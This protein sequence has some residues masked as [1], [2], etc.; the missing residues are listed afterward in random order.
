MLK[1][2][3]SSLLNYYKSPTEFTVWKMNGKKTRFDAKEHMYRTT[4]IIIY[5]THNVFTT[6]NVPRNSIFATWIFTNTLNFPLNNHTCDGIKMKRKITL[7]TKTTLTVTHRSKCINF[8]WKSQ[9]I[10][11]LACFGNSSTL[12]CFIESFQLL[13]IKLICLVFRS[14]KWTHPLFIIFACKWNY[15]PNIYIIYIFQ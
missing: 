12:C 8:K 10:F 3:F 5:H 7:E 13:V 4:I 9:R 2:F 1:Y 6:W 14:F 11:I 15:I